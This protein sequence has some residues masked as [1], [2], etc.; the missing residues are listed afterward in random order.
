MLAGSSATCPVTVLDAAAWLSIRLG[1]LV[2][3]L[4]GS[5]S[6]LLYAALCALQRGLSIRLCASVSASTRSNAH[7]RVR[8]QMQHFVWPPD[9][10]AGF[11]LLGKRLLAQRQLSVLRL[12]LS[13]RL[14]ADVY[15]A[16][17]SDTHSMVLAQMQHSMSARHLI[18][19]HA[20]V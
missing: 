12:G 4:F 17:S 10:L 14:L 18:T 7:S 15:A 13:I 16:I 19:F 5:G 11:V 20:A 8:A 3:A 2:R 6:V 9:F 1:A